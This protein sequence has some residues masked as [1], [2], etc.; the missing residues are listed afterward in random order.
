M[1]GVKKLECERIFSSALRARSD[2]YSLA[3][4]HAK[5]PLTM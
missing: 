5:Y 3:E 4:E 2:S 1:A